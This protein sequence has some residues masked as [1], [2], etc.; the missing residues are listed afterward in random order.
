LKK[1][2]AV[3]ADNQK[4]L[5]KHHLPNGV[6]FAE[7]TIIL[8][9]KP[10]E[11]TSFD[12]V[13][14]VKFAIKYNTEYKNVKVGHAGTLDPMAD[15]LLIVCTGKYTKL[16]EAL[17]GNEKSYQARVKLGVT[18]SSF[19]REC[20]EENH[21]PFDHLTHDD[22]EI[23]RAKFLGTIDQKPPIYS[24]VKVKGQ[25]A[26]KIA[27]RGGDIDLISRVVEIKEFT[28][29]DISL[30]TIAFDVTV[31]KGTY[32]RSLANDM[33]EAL[34]VGGYLA[35]LTRKSIGSYNLADALQIDDL[36]AYIKTYNS[37][38]PVIIDTIST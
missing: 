35:G 10:L 6:N 4:L 12:I 29:T 27:R 15:G 32:I 26:Y 5:T 16:L 33:G 36:V 19:D 18:T 17:S 8:I 3:V 38:E 11:W 7:G 28:F 37:A 14:K 31:S 25:T 22:L 30:P 34:G 2:K 24:A 20:A 1:K 9:D 21:K 13:N 23:V